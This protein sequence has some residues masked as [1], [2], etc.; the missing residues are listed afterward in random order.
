MWDELTDE[1]FF[2]AP[3]GD[4]GSPERERSDGVRDFI[5]RPAAQ[6]AGLGATI[7][8]DEIAKPGQ[9]TLQVIEHVLK[10]KAAV[11][12]LTGA[13]PNVYYE[14]AIRHTARLPTVLIAD[15]GER[16]ALPFDLQGM[17]TIFFSDNSL[18]S[19]DR[20]RRELTKQLTAALTG[21][22]DS[23]VVASVNLKNLEGGDEQSQ[24]LASL[25]NTVDT[26]AREF[27]G[28]ASRASAPD[29][30]IEPP[31]RGGGL[32]TTLLE[33]WLRE[34]GFETVR[35][36]VRTPHAD[37]DLVAEND[38]AVFIAEHRFGP[39]RVSEQAV[40]EVA[41][42]PAPFSTTRDRAI[43]RALVVTSSSQFSST[44]IDRAR[45]EGVEL[46]EIGASGLVARVDDRE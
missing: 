4:E 31:V 23:P 30:P 41:S 35:R 6:D 16:G 38:Q 12:D 26:L 24:I 1:C 43:R 9:I 28:Y 32:R 34:E 21:A 29:L 2:I 36:E 33:R 17:R 19:A 25:V 11:V 7:R 5:V 8:A 40:A 3:I 39:V 45:E 37:Y 14:M 20:C 46:Y 15:D 42:L 22:V 44:A 13:N 18:K 10:A 27:R